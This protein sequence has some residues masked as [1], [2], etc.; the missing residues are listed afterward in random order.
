[1]GK[2]RKQQ[3]YMGKIMKISE[4]MEIHGKKWEKIEKMEKNEKN[5]KSRKNLEK[6]GKF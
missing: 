4:K 1:M 2:Y 5:V 6:K 3:N